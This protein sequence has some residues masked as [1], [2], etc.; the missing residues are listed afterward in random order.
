[1]A[2]LTTHRLTFHAS[3]LSSQP[4]YQQGVIKAGPVL[5]HRKGLYRK[6]RVWLQLSPDIISTYH[7]S[8]DEDKIKPIRS[9]LRKWLSVFY[10]AHPRDHKSVSSV[11]DVIQTERRPRYIN[12][13]YDSAQ[14]TVES[15][16]E[17]DTEESA[18]DWKREL[19]GEFLL[20]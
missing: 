2:H 11:K 6:K 10:L 19:L 1:M 12:I 7:S 16:V 9:I 8:R 4:N 3:L 20:M 5:V 13:L 17:F 15:K 18:C 14:G